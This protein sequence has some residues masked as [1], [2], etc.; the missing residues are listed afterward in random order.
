MNY[1]PLRYPG[2]KTKIAPLVYLV[3]QKANVVNGTYI[4]PFAGGAGVA[5]SLLLTGKVQNIVIN[6]Y[7][8]AIYAFWHS[9]VFNTEKFIQLIKDTSVTIEEWHIQK[10]VFDEKKT[11]SL[12]KLGFATFFLNRTNRSGILKAGPIGGYDQTGNYLIDARFNKVDLIKRI[13]KIG[14]HRSRIFIYNLEI[15]KFI[16]K[17]LPLYH[18][19]SFVYFD[20]P[21]YNKGKELYINFFY[22]KDHK[23]I[24]NL[25][26]TLDIDWMV[27][28][29][30][31][32][33]IKK[34]YANK[35]QRIFDLNY[36][37]A[38]KGKNSEIMVLSRNIWP[39]KNELSLLKINLR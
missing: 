30:N 36:S 10:K 14:K 38:N 8:K 22:P 33:E 28:Y 13:S 7:D 39:E 11:R 1:S 5:L 18:D 16:K 34:I 29:D 32:E 24:A 23:E 25:I 19:N 12:L 37:V 15:K 6:D 2:G 4:E 3:M 27:T 20:P 31:V 9:V 35:E 17:V 21:Y 26:F